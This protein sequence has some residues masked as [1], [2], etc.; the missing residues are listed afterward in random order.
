MYDV[1]YTKSAERYFKKI[2]DKQLL[3]AFKEA[4]EKLRVNP[5]TQYL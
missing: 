5:Y 2:R 1:R 3:S 4:I